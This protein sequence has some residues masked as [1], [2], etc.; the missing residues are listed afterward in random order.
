VEECCCCYANERAEPVAV[1]LLWG[2]WARGSMRA[3]GRA[4]ATCS[5]FQREC[6]GATANEPQKERSWSRHNAAQ[7]TT[8]QQGSVLEQPWTRAAGREGN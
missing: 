1:L 5:V 6:S 3:S 4:G 7:R 2:R 8:G